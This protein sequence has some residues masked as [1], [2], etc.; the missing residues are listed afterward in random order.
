MVL[1]TAE[2]FFDLTDFPHRALFEK[3]RFVWEALGNLDA[4]LSNFPPFISRENPLGLIE[5]EVEPGAY[6]I[7]PEKIMIGK[8]SRVEAG[9]YIRGPAIIGEKCQIRH[10]AYLRGNVILGHRVVIG[11]ASEVK[12]SIFLNG[13]QAPHFAYVGD[14]IIG[15]RVNLGAGTKCANLRL[16][17]Q[18]IT[19]KIA[20]KRV[21]TALRKLGAII[22][23]E[24]EIGCNS[25]INPGT[26]I[27]KR[28]HC[29]PGAI[30]SGC[31]Q[32][33]SV[34]KGSGYV[35]SA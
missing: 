24:T 5:G 2:S 1:L 7:N 18:E 4:F 32:Q 35:N 20:D 14:S 19:I 31:I 17:R 34:I 13:A 15:A 8:G 25:V 9:A 26:L 10:G 27:G 16:D 33:G 28:V 21:A 29:Y 6:L 12:H 30:L 22:G 23:D 11:H 3:E